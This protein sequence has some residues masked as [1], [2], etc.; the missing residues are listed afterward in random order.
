[1]SLSQ[2]LA[3]GENGEQKE[4]RLVMDPRRFTP[5]LHANL[6][7]EILALRREVESKNDL[8]VSLEEH[9]VMIKDEN[10]N[11]RETVS[12]NSKEKRTLKRQLNDLEDST[13]A[14][15]EEIATERDQLNVTL[16][17]TKVKLDSS[18]KRA[19]GQEVEKE[20]IQAVWQQD[21]GKWDTE[22]K[23]LELKIHI[24]ESRLK[25]VLAE[26][27]AQTPTQHGKC[28]DSIYSLSRDR[29]SSRASGRRS[30]VSNHRDSFS[31]DTSIGSKTLADE[32]NSHAVSDAESEDCVS[33]GALPEEADLFPR[34]STSLSNRQ[35][36]KALKL[37]GLHIDTAEERSVPRDSLP[38]EH[39]PT[40]A[41]NDS[42][43]QST[44]AYR[45]GATQYSLPPSP[46]L[47]PDQR[48]STI[49]EFDGDS[50][51]DDLRARPSSRVMISSACQT[52]EVPLSPP[53]TPL[54]SQPESSNIANLEMA[55]ASTQTSENLFT[56]TTHSINNKAFPT[57]K[58]ASAQVNIASEM[59]STAAQTEGIRTDERLTK[60]PIYLHPTIIH[61]I[62][63]AP[64]SAPSPTPSPMFK[65]EIENSSRSTPPSTS[66]QLRPQSAGKKS[67]ISRSSQYQPQ[68]ESGLLCT[69]DELSD[70]SFLSR[71]LVKKS[72]SKVQDSWQVVSLPDDALPGDDRKTIVDTEETV[73]KLPALEFE[74]FTISQKKSQIDLQ[75]QKL[76]QASTEEDTSPDV[77]PSKDRQPSK[78]VKANMGRAR[79][80]SEPMRI[81]S[82]EQMES[83]PISGLPYP[84]PDRSSSRKF[85]WLADDMFESP[86]RSSSAYSRASRPATRRSVLRK[87]RSY[88]G[89]QGPKS[90]RSLSPE[91]FDVF[92]DSLNNIPPPLPTNHITSPT[93][94]GFRQNSYPVTPTQ[95]FAPNTESAISDQ[96]TVV[97]AIA[98]TM[99]GEWMYKYVRRRKSFGIPDEPGTGENSVNGGTRHQRW[100]WIAPYERAV[101]WSSKQP[102]SGTALMGKNGRKC[103]FS[104]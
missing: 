71:K 102:T 41:N 2:T 97:D 86:T 83:D 77:H 63:P 45:D 98:Q 70:D 82:R 43:N 74:N 68:D 11:L 23:T 8:V 49:T 50:M 6:V 58:D 53:G 79:S 66:P 75:Q 38:N 101:L 5:T 30:P 37:L 57:S 36:I 9:M 78:V 92:T 76:K 13:L 90:R 55:T 62:S 59:T 26:V 95:P 40:L 87:S 67:L 51:L 7:S 4:D 88:I 32:L 31:N 34:S 29:A 35:S 10:A 18:Q 52:I 20:E 46:Q 80:P 48:L 103:E 47:T 1:M 73:P 61:P 81:T 65:A 21:Q 89:S 93:S 33:P 56:I 14:A 19:R 25:T 60:L 22:R 85:L 3:F 84:V 39:I 16:T 24:V 96:A 100:V 91:A 15:I 27:A 42:S 104:N 64:S 12:A 69:D 54:H 99:I 17:D 72:L 44:S 94:S 28:I